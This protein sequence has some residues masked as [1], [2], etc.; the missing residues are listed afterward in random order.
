MKNIYKDSFL[1]SLGALAY[2]AFVALLMQ[3]GET[4]FGKFDNILGPITFLLLF[5]VSALIVG[6]LILGKPFMLYLDN[7]KQEAL[8]LFLGTA[9]WLIIYVVTI[10][11]VT[12]LITKI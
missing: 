1:S 4:I 8:S 5:V 2:I 10:L 6:A 3:N 12:I 7:K 11:L 9:C